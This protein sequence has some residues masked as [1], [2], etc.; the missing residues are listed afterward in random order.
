MKKPVV[1]IPGDTESLLDQTTLVDSQC[2]AVAQGTQLMVW[3][4]LPFAI[5]GATLDNYKAKLLELAQ[6]DT[7]LASKGI[8][9]RVSQTAP[10]E[11]FMAMQLALDPGTCTV[12]PNMKKPQAYIINKA[13]KELGLELTILDHTGVGSLTDHPHRSEETFNDWKL[14]ARELK[15]IIKNSHAA[16]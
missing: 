10:A 13:A 9:M 3:L 15:K 8:S 2:I 11:S 6:L 7:D 16:L 12:D 1:Y 5:H 4:N 14:V